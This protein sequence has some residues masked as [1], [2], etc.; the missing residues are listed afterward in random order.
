MQQPDCAPISLMAR[1]RSPHFVL[2]SFLT[3]LPLWFSLMVCITASHVQAEEKFKPVH[4][5]IAGKEVSG[6]AVAIS[7]G[8]ETYVS[9]EVLKTLGIESKVSAK[10]DTI[11]VTLPH[12]TKRKE[13]ALA[14]PKGKGM[15]AL[16]RVA[17]LVDG[18][19]LRPDAPGKD[20]DDEDARPGDTVYLL[21]RVTEA[22]FA[23]G[24]IHI[25]T[26]FPVPFHARTLME[27]KPVRGYVDCVGAFVSEKFKASPLPSGERRVLRLRTAQNSVDVARVV[28]E[29]SEGNFLKAGDLAA[30][31][32]RAI[33]AS[34]NDIK[35]KPAPA[36]AHVSSNP[37]SKSASVKPDGKKS[38]STPP[39]KVAISTVPAP[40]RVQA[41]GKINGS[42]PTA[43]LKPDMHN[44]GDTHPSGRVAS[45][46]TPSASNRTPST[47][48]PRNLP[49]DPDV[50][51]TVS[52][53]TDTDFTAESQLVLR[54]KAPSRGDA[55]KREGMPVEV[56]DLAFVPVD[57]KLCRV[58]LATS[59]KPGVSIHY[60]PGTTQMV[61]DL[62]NTRLSLPE[63]DNGERDVMHPLVHK[64][65]AA[66][67]EGNRP[68]TRLTLDM[69]RIA[70][71]TISTTPDHCTLELRLPRNA[72]G[73]LA[74]KT[75]VVDAGHGG[76]ATGATGHNGVY[77]IYEKDVTLAIALKLRTALEACG[78]R[79]VMTRDHDAD[80]GL[81]ARPGL[82]ND[83]GADLFISIHND[84]NE[85][86]NTASGTST[87]YHMS[88]PSCRA[89]ATCVQHA[90]MAVTGLP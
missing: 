66:S 67:V 43:A 40:D 29:L 20:D 71:F 53:K 74:D 77:T 6:K 59:G 25:T 28:V 24:Q 56:H 85:R 55:V 45:N 84:S 82:A 72:Y 1:M 3:F 89:F 19:V 70:G 33:T 78:A 86:V 48:I 21:A 68:T 52:D 14:R 80:V 34:L 49:T 10:G 63:N 81:D 73:V 51:L 46:R 15:L 44:S 11:L 30:N 39:V 17:E 12:A 90:V 76:S 5:K 87:Y 8:E 83:I 35:G 16:S 42:G 50:T 47:A 79:V 32:S 38:A 22:R 26:S 62:A 9:P 57:D 69:T 64:I 36:V 23:A 60:I 75:I 61:M 54:E 65:T 58:E 41:P 7:N 4:L 37:P 13:I 2:R 31:S 88:D 27:G 18:V